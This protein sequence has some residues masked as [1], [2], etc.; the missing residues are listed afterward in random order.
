MKTNIHLLSIFL[1]FSPVY[2]N[3]E[4]PYPRPAFLPST[5]SATKEVSTYTVDDVMGVA[6]TFTHQ[7][8]P[9]HLYAVGK[10]YDDGLKE[11]WPGAKVP[12]QIDAMAQIILNAPATASRTDIDNAF[13]NI[14]YILRH[15]FDVTAEAKADALVRSVNAQTDPLKKARAIELASSLFEELLDPRL[16][17][18]EKELL[19]DGTVEANVFIT[20]ERRTKITRRGRARERILGNLSVAGIV[21]DLHPFFTV[22]QAAGC[23]ALKAWLTA[24]WGQIITKCAEAKAKP[25]RELPHVSV[26]PWD[27][28]W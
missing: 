20:D 18:F 15:V 26:A 8:P 12:T 9:G 7:L 19:D 14:R 23:A 27:A 10:K 3:A 16:I 25:N 28:R 5:P 2:G 1:V 17:H 22:D 24:N 6:V 21:V 11:N 13:R 4:D